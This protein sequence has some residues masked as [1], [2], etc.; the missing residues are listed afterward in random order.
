LCQTVGAQDVIAGTPQAYTALANLLKQP[1]AEW[2]KYFE[3]PQEQVDDLATPEFLRWLAVVQAQHPNVQQFAH[4]LEAVL[5]GRVVDMKA[6]PRPA[7]PD[8][9]AEE[10][11]PTRD[12]LAKNYRVRCTVKLVVAAP[13]ERFFDT[14]A[15]RIVAAGLEHK[16]PR[17]VKNL[18]RLYVMAGWPVTASFKVF[19][20]LRWRL[21]KGERRLEIVPEALPL[22]LVGIREDFLYQPPTVAKYLTMELCP[23]GRWAL[24][25]VYVSSM[26]LPR[27]AELDVED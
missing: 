23:S 4:R 8:R 9:V 15:L 17:V 7:Q 13:P 1:H 10:P 21:W 16:D 24:H 2:E 3:M 14:R 25:H 5:S 12:F 6:W 19:N 26:Y 20:W 18:A 27:D 22:K 11:Q